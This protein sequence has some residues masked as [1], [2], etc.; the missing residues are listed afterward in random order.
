ML[1][2]KTLGLLQRQGQRLDMGHIWV[3]VADEEERLQY[4]RELQ[5]TGLPEACIVI[6]R[7]GILQQRNFIVEWV[8]RRFPPLKHVVSLDD[9]LDSLYYKVRSGWDA[10]GGELGHLEEV[11]QGGLEALILHA[12]RAMECTGSYLWGVSTSQNAYFMRSEGI[13]T[14]N[15]Q[16]NGYMYGF[17]SRPD[18]DLKNAFFSATEDRERSVR[19]FAKDGIILRYK[20]YTAKTN[21]FKNHGG[22]QDTYA[23]SLVER[24]LA[25]KEEERQGH[26]QIERAFPHLYTAAS[27]CDR[28]RLETMLGGFRVARAA[29]P[30]YTYGLQA[31]L[32]PR[33]RGCRRELPAV[34]APCEP[35]PVPAN[36][37]TPLGKTSRRRPRPSVLLLTALSASA[38]GSGDLPGPS[39]LGTQ[40]REDDASDDAGSSH[41]DRPDPLTLLQ[42][43]QRL[44][45]YFDGS[46]A[47]PEEGWPCPRCSFQNPVLAVAC[48]VCEHVRAHGAEFTAYVDSDS[49]SD[50]APPE[51]DNP[52]AAHAREEAGEP[53]SKRLRQ[54]GWSCPACT[55][56]NCKMEAPVCEVCLTPRCG[57]G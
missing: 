38:A 19:Y 39:G 44:G 36:V 23:G 50:A 32:Q 52:P 54:D 17:R 37:P 4:V 41:G 10:R 20:M 51:G 56:W 40:C 48:E 21:C 31:D 9:D 15:G 53:C 11:Q 18:S 42:G 28:R 29:D 5:H 49:E 12:A 1:A 14:G 24:N 47:P 13:A 33:Q 30:R 43:L 46:V 7:L 55:F 34:P 26:A 27:V 2:N 35:A 6:G 45:S 57:D 22:I 8:C 16:I 3:F 25:R